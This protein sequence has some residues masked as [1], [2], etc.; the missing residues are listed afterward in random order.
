MFFSLA[1]FTFTAFTFT[2]FTF[3]YFHTSVSEGN[4]LLDFFTA[5]TFIA[6]S[7][8]IL[9]SIPT[10]ADLVFSG[11]GGKVAVCAHRYSGDTNTGHRTLIQ[12][13]LKR[14]H[15]ICDRLTKD[16]LQRSHM[17]NR[18]MTVTPMTTL[19]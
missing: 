16:T 17:T 15:K 8:S 1:A 3:T 6:V 2:A 11:A 9:I 18:L 5:F 7:P 4:I 14:R 19:F 13:R 12:N 10:F